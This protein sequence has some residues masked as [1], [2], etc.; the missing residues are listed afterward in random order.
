MVAL[1]PKSSIN[2]KK[3]S[4]CYFSSKDSQNLDFAVGFGYQLAIS[5]TFLSKKG[6]ISLQ[7]GLKTS[8][9]V[10]SIFCYCIKT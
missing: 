10:S 1:Y 6:G 2:N 8:I 4:N 7:L 9:A 5:N 3:D